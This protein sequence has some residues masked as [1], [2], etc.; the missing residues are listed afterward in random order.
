VEL[1][2]G[3]AKQLLVFFNVGHSVELSRGVAK[4]L[5]KITHK[6]VHV[7]A[8]R[9][10]YKNKESIRASNEQ[11]LFLWSL[12]NT[13]SSAAPQIPLCRRMLGSNPELLQLWN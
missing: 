9:K 1:G 10:L 5:L 2:W 7:P 3:V 6:A 12:F 11:F 4:Q 8:N 13:A